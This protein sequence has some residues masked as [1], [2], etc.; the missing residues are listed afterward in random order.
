MVR[1]DHILFKNIAKDLYFTK[2]GS[3][4]FDYML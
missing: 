1:K 3:L 4:T 2:G